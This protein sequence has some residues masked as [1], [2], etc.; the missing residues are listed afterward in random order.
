LLLVSFPFDQNIAFKQY[1]IRVLEAFIKANHDFAATTADTPVTIDAL[2]NDT[3]NV[4]ELQLS[5][6]PVTN[7]GTAEVVD[8]QIVFTPAPGFSGLTDLNYTI[9]SVNNACALGTVSI[10]VLPEQGTA[11]SDTLRVFTTR[12]R[13]QLIFAPDNAVPAAEPQSG[14]MTLENG[15]MAYLPDEGFIGDEYLEYSVPGSQGSTVFHI[16]VLDLQPNTFAAE[17][18]VYAAVNASRT[19]NVLHNDLYSVFADCVVFGAPRYGSLVEDIPNGQVTYTP[20]A[21]WSGVD[22]FTYSS[23]PF[24]CVGEAEIATVYIFVDNFDP[25]DD[26]THITAPEGTPVGLTYDAPGG[27][28]EWSVVTAP[29]N[30]VLL[31][32]PVTGKLDYLPTPGTA[33]QTDEFTLRYCLNPAATGECSYSTEVVITVDITPASADACVD[34]DCVWPGDTNN[35][36]VVDVGE[37]QLVPSVLSGLDPKRSQRRQPQAHRC[38]R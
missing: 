20:P 26:E 30:G 17:D 7:A 6:L 9:C 37:N 3:T 12:D 13:A 22:Q 33:G 35:D 4:G 23:K 11:I 2:V 38:R 31:P 16:T 27:T 14:S 19:F 29:S 8:G 25:A 24:N 15:V 32:N 21:N 28:T 5:G 10:N 36:G 18:R 34:D 1:E